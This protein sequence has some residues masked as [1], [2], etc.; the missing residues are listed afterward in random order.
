MIG[1]CPYHIVLA[2][3]GPLNAVKC[4]G[5]LLYD[6]LALCIFLCFWLL[7]IFLVWWAVRNEAHIYFQ[8]VKL[9][10][11]S[12]HNALFIRINDIFVN[13]LLLFFLHLTSLSLWLLI[14]MDMVFV[15]CCEC[16]SMVNLL[17]DS[18]PDF[19]CLPTNAHFS[20]FVGLQKSLLCSITY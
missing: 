17:V 7:Q 14:Q 6:C 1:Q 3:N 18:Y 16:V 2:T 10:N 15:F 11:G 9:F 4:V 12:K 5:M 20:L 13:L 8:K 19:L